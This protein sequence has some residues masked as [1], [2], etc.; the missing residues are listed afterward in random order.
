M[1]DSSELLTVD[2]NLYGMLTKCQNCPYFSSIDQVLPKSIEV[3]CH[4]CGKVSINLEDSCA[5]KCKNEE[6]KLI[7]Q[8][9]YV[10]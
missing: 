4:M 3:D 6:L 7:C 10:F 2:K 8:S 5:T 1:I 9:F